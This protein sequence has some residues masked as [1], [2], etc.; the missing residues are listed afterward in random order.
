MHF[1]LSSSCPLASRWPGQWVGRTT[2]PATKPWQGRGGVFLL[3]G[4]EESEAVIHQLGK[5]ADSLQSQVLEAE[6]DGGSWMG[7]QTG[8]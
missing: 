3:L 1:S 8:E 6:G 2:L 4:S 5:G 7:K